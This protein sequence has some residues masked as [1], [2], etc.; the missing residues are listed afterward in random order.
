MD[1]DKKNFVLE[2]SLIFV[3]ALITLLIFTPILLAVGY[4]LAPYAVDKYAPQYARQSTYSP[5]EYYN[6]LTDGC[7]VVVVADMEE[8]YG[9]YDAQ[10]AY[11]ACAE[12]TENAKA[13]YVYERSR[14]ARRERNQSPTPTK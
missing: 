7:V 14:Q 13:K 9:V 6:G 11:S 1:D 5:V 12:M 3:V 10:L 2:F 4:Y 8:D